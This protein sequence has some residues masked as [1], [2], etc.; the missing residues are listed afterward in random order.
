MASEAAPDA[1]VDE[2]RLLRCRSVT[3]HWASLPDARRYTVLVSVD[4][5]DDWR[6]LATRNACGRSRVTGTTSMVD[7]EPTTGG[8]TVVRR[9]YYEVEAF[10]RAGAGARLIATTTPVPV[11]MP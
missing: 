6:P 4:G 5:N 7:V 11:R 2:G 8:A 3:L 9:L 10:D 1:T